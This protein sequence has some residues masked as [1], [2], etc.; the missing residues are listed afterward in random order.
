MFDV[1]SIMVTKRIELN[2]FDEAMRLFGSKD[3]HLRNIERNYGVQIFSRQSPSRGDFIISVRGSSSKVEKAVREIEEARRRGY[4]DMNKNEFNESNN[5][6]EYDISSQEEETGNNG[7]FSSINT[8]HFSKNLTHPVRHNEIILFSK[9]SQKPIHPRGKHQEDYV[10]C[11]ENYD[12]VFAIGP[13]GTGKTF[14]AVAMALKYLQ[15]GMIS[16]IILTRPIVEAGEK[17][18]Y[19]PGDFEEK[20]DP[21]LRPLYDAFYYMIGVDRFRALRDDDI[22]EIVPLAYMR[23]RTLENAF[24][25]LDEAQNATSLQ[26]FMLLTRLGAGSKVVVTGDITQIDLPQKDTSGL[27]EAPLIFKDVE[28]VGMIEFV[29]KD[30]V[31]H[32]VVKKIITAYQKWHHTKKAE[33]K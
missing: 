2:N 12:V 28:G 29:E 26:L 10:R 21:Y 32:P 24:V 8:H 16:K 7:N 6:G 5:N 20:V 33:N 30:V 25:I 18:G 19:L 4:F 14:I 23:G 3:E 15:T 9:L 1:S 13:A 31:R 27:M 17:L 22:I 11:I